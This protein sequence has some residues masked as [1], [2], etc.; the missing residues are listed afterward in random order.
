MAKARSRRTLRN[1][2]SRNRR[3]GMFGSSIEEEFKKKL[4]KV[5]RIK[6]I[7]D[8][9]RN[10]GNVDKCFSYPYIDPDLKNEIE[11]ILQTSEP[12]VE[13]LKNYIKEKIKNPKKKIAFIDAISDGKKRGIYLCVA[14]YVIEEVEKEPKAH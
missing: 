6:D 2:K 13:E 1:R 4:E 8:D 12:G 14:N 9:C 11:R 10:S 3:G 7:L 5:K